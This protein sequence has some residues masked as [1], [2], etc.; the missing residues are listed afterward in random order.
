[1]S[2]SALVFQKVGARL[3]FAPYPD[4]DLIQSLEIVLQIAMSSDRQLGGVLSSVQTI[5]AG[6]TRGF[7]AVNADRKTTFI[8]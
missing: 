8:F 1:M 7:H 2:S 6:R 5:C 3:R 4:R